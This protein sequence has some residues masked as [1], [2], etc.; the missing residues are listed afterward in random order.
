MIMFKFADL[1]RFGSGRSYDKFAALCGLFVLLVF[2][3]RPVVDSMFL[4]SMAGFTHL[5]LGFYRQ[6]TRGRRQFARVLIIFILAWLVVLNLSVRATFVIT[7][8]LIFVHYILDNYFLFGEKLSP[9]TVV[10]LGVL[11][12]L[13][14]FGEQVGAFVAPTVAI[15]TC[16]AIFFSIV[17][18]RW[19]RHGDF[20]SRVFAEI[21][22]VA[23]FAVYQ[24]AHS[25]FNSL[26]YLYLP[27]GSLHYFNWYV[28]L[29]CHFQKDRT[30]LKQY[31]LELVFFAFICTVG[32]AIYFYSEASYLWMEY[33]FGA[34][35]FCVWICTHILA[36]LNVSQIDRI[37]PSST[38][39]Q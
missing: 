20:N 10:A 1:A 7:I 17:V 39:I 12:L 16:S 24:V 3:L 4:F 31:R 30:K 29:E 36:S 27:I 13:T 11:F 2:V 14:L 26:L 35:Y 34:P 32:A 21:I 9:P 15:G 25:G 18:W 6:I 8:A 5:F 19:R 33:I 38:D 37:R 23:M 22:L 28:S